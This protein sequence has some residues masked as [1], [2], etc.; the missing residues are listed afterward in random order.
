MITQKGHHYF[1]QI[2]NYFLS[3]IFP[4]AKGVEMSG[5]VRHDKWYCH[6]PLA[7]MK[8]RAMV[9]GLK[10]L[11]LSPLF[12]TPLF[13]HKKRLIDYINNLLWK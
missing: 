8:A 5:Y 11:P 13:P 2:P 4:N 12:L 10:Y 7:E 6:M 3:P 1:C 9:Y